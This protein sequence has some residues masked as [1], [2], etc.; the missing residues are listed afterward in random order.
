MLYTSKN[1]ACIA[2][3]GVT[4]NIQ[5]LTIHFG[6]HEKDTLASAINYAKYNYIG[7]LAIF[8]KNGKFYSIKK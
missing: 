7:D 2:L 3:V 1:Y 8:D 4:E 6:D 5:I